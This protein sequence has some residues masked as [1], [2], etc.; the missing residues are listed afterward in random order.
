MRKKKRKDPEFIK[1]LEALL[2]AEVFGPDVLVLQKEEQT[3]PVPMTIELLDYERDYNKVVELS[4]RFAYGSQTIHISK[5]DVM[6]FFSS[7]AVVID[8]ISDEYIDKAER[9]TNILL[10]LTTLQKAMHTFTNALILVQTSSLQAIDMKE[11]NTIMSFIVGNLAKYA[12]V[13]YGI[14]TRDYL[15]NRI[16]LLIALNRPYKMPEIYCKINSND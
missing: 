12:S 7:L 10:K 5:D 4:Y 2:N 9:V 16:R 3:L 15:K 14:G 6:S 11:L 8:T 1:P 13:K